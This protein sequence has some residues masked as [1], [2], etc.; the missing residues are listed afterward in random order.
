M[1]G[2]VKALILLLLVGCGGVDHDPVA[3]NPRDIDGSFVAEMLPP[4]GLVGISVNGGLLF[5][6]TRSRRAPP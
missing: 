4:V 6:A 2:G 5:V 3:G 1:V